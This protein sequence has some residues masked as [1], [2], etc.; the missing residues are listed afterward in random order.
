MD[1]Q[2][3]HFNSRWSFD[4]FFNDPD[5]NLFDIDWGSCTVRFHSTPSSPYYINLADSEYS[6]EIPY[7]IVPL[8]GQFNLFV[9]INTC[10]SC[11]FDP[12]KTV[13]E[14]SE[15]LDEVIDNE[16]R[17]TLMAFIIKSSLPYAAVGTLPIGMDNA[18]E[19]WRL[20]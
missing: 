13:Q 10:S 15:D 16:A 7:L 8:I 14:I 9:N 6:D 1:I 11:L 5:A 3:S 2:V 4:Y 20:L 18:D 12:S 19:P 17:S